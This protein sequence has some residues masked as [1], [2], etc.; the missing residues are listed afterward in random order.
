MDALKKITLGRTELK[1]TR[2]AFGA[3]PIQRVDLVTARA[4]L[5][6]AHGDGIN[7]FDTAHGYTDS[8]EKIGD[9]LAEVRG[10]I[11]IAT[12]SP[13]TDRAGVLRDVELSLQRMRT[14]HVDILQL[15]NPAPLPDP[16]D[17]ESA[18]AGLAEARRKG[19]T[20]FIGISNHRPDVAR[21]VVECGL[22]DTLQFPLNG[23][24][25]PEEFAVARLC[26]ERNVGFMAMKP[27]CGGLL[28]SPL[29]TF[30]AFREF[31]NVAALWG[32]QRMEELDEIARLEANP[33]PMTAELR[34]MV[35]TERR[36]LGGEFC[37]GCGYCLPC[38][39]EIPINFA[40]RMGLVV[41]RLPWRPFVTPEWQEK[42]SRI[43]KCQDCGGC[44]DRCPY[45]LDTPKLLR[46][47]LAEYRIFCEEHVGKGNAPAG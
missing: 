2:T 25:S 12:K 3:L 23:I 7:L 29:I 39:A 30:A 16:N 31:P 8:E 14:D 9:A 38:P 19:M 47:A 45:H 33:P 10:E 20:R 35:E 43:E 40:A 5:R 17:P 26:A 32:I 42:M 36:E 41:R 13:A 11:H 28:K 27:M 44:R 21:Q 15:H 24:S 34:E 4:I 18:Y 46:K 37:R 1:V 6:R 22:Y